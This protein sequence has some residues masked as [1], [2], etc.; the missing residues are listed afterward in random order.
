[1]DIQK[2]Y[3]IT[4]TA[5]LDSI[6]VLHLPMWVWQFVYLVIPLCDTPLQRSCWALVSVCGVLQDRY[7]L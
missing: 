5:I 1:M 3:C 4:H 2:A 6:D 7:W